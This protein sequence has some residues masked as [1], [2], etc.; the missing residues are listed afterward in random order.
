[1]TRAGLAVQDLALGIFSA[2]DNYFSIKHV[3]KVDAV[4]SFG[5]EKGRKNRTAF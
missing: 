1:M 5:Q 2:W 4:Q 3:T